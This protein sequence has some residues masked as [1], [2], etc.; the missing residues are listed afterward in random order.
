MR[1]LFVHQNFPA[2]YLHLAAALAASPG[3]EIV[4]LTMN[5]FADPHGRIRSLRYAPRRGSSRHIHPWAGDFE[6]KMIRAEA[7]YRAALKL[8]AEGFAPDVMC[9]HPGW[10]EG[11]L[12]KDVWPQTPVLL[13]CEYFYS[14]VGG[15]VSF[16]PEFPDV[17]T[18]GRIAGKNASNLLHLELATAGVAPTAW[19]KS[20]FPAWFRP[21]ISVIHDGIDT[22]LVRPRPDAGIEVDG[23][24]LTRDDEVVTFVNRNLEPYRGY[25]RFMRALPELMRRRPQAHVVIVGGDGVSYGA[26]PPPGRSWKEIFL[27]EV[28]GSIDA[29]RLHFLGRVPYARFLSVLKVSRVHVYLT[30]PFVLS[31][32]LLEAMSCG[33]AVVASRTTPLLDVIEDRRTGRLV[34]FFNQEEL[35]S[36]VDELLDDSA[37]RAALGEAARRAVVSSCDL[38]R[39]CLPAQMRL[40]SALMPRR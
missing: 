3:A 25:H 33:C 28:R 14:A 8:K 18:S 29:S 17:D 19:Q 24:C 26:K 27:S 23:R 37:G 10:G 12:L 32:S 9:V 5:A 35:V 7:A 40:L 36:T 20:G 4:A 1:V 31:W 6:T 22:D 34:D 21:A 39:I 15:D 38:R 2:Q 30:Y 13:Y 16:D 11:I